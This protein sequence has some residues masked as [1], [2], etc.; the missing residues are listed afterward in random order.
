MTDQL[1]PAYLNLVENGELAERSVA[2]KEILSSCTLCPWNCMVDRLSGETGQ[3][4]IGG[5]A[6][7]YSYMAH[8]GEEKPLIGTRG[9][10][11]I[12]FSGCN[13]HCQYCQNSDISQENYGMGVSADVLAS[14]MLDLQSQG[15]HN[16]NLVSP[17][18]IVPQFLDA[19]LVAVEEGLRLP[20]IYNTGG[21]DKVS[22]LQLLDSI[23]DI[24]L[25]DMKYADKDIAQRFS[26]VK[27]Y[28]AINRAAIKEM[29]RQAGDLE[30]DEKGIAIRGL[31]VRHLVLPNEL[32]CTRTVAAF[33]A[34]EISTNTYINVMDQY[35]PEYN[36]CNFPQLNRRV[37]R[38]EYMVAV[39]TVK[40]AGLHRLG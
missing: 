24:Y 39:E 3:C 5:Q 16:I 31:M 4:Q 11:T 13:L 23:V 7:V 26:G 9:S 12:F 40:E 38:Q 14:M 34:E 29:H 2:A 28:P 35:R 15:C 36:A 1:Y 33:I 37:T 6:R 27:D 30:V 20:I 18:H 22:S 32:A 10:G 17:T 21:Y 25:P 8:R 19:L